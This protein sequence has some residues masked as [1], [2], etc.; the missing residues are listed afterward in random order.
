M[1]NKHTTIQDCLFRRNMHT[2][3]LLGGNLHILS[4]Q[5]I[6]NELCIDTMFSS[7]AGDLIVEDSYF[8][9]NMYL[10][11][12]NIYNYKALFLNSAFT[13][14][15]VNNGIIYI[16][17]SPNVTF[18]SCTFTYNYAN[19]L[20]TVSAVR[21]GILSFSNCS[22]TENEGINGGGI[23]VEDFTH[24]SVMNS[25]FSSN[26]ASQGGAIYSMKIHNM[27]IEHSSFNDNFAALDGGAIVIS[28][29]TLNLYRTNI[30]SNRVNFTGGAIK[31]LGILILII[32]IISFYS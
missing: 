11:A 5:F 19:D 9:V 18:D 30:F 7:I 12:I 16:S 23:Y 14:N 2:I 28:N 15:T 1:N 8:D 6:Y 21:G 3:D 24:F 13:N 4:S 29:S 22:F 32:S 26:T 31:L 17:N 20:S 27:E 10:T 25:T